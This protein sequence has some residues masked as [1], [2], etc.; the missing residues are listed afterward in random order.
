MD[1][2]VMSS[3][4]DDGYFV[5]DTPGFSKV[6]FSIQTAL[7]AFTERTVFLSRERRSGV[8]FSYGSAGC[9][10]VAQAVA[11]YCSC[12]GD[13]SGVWRQCAFQS[14]AHAE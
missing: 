10:L 5:G 12:S 6:R 13:G 9:G 1:E 2:D 11:N 7:C 4:G 14:I 3:F 8:G